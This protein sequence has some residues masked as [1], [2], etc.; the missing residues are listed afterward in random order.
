[1][2]CLVPGLRDKYRIELNIVIPDIAAFLKIALDTLKLRQWIVTASLLCPQALGTEIP[3]L[4]RCLHVLSWSLMSPTCSREPRQGQRSL[5]KD[6]CCK[7]KAN[8]VADLIKAKD[9]KN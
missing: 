6:G 7:V 5:P 1:M 8:G 2:S 4:K 9:E 3:L